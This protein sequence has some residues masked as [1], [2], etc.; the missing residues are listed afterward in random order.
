MKIYTSYFG[1]WRALKNN[2]VM[3]IG[4]S[5]HPPSHFKGMS[6]FNLAPHSNML[7]MPSD[8]YDRM[9]AKKVL[10]IT[11]QVKIIQEIEL[12][13]KTAGV[14]AVA[15]CCFE[16]E[17]KECHRYNV[18]EWLNSKG[19]DVQEFQSTVTEKPKKKIEEQSNQMGLF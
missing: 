8:M 11:N 15:L 10:G 5:V 9:F 14:E 19:Y 3:M 12:I 1:N 13:A 2:N 4:I 6:M 17:Q 7:N 16:K 18:A